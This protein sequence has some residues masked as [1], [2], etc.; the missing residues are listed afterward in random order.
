MSP[1]CSH[2]SSSIVA[3]VFVGSINETLAQLFSS[4]ALALTLVIHGEV[5]Q[6]TAAQLASGAGLVF[7]SV[8][9]GRHVDE[10]NFA[11][12]LGWTHRARGAGVIDNGS[13]AN[14]RRL[15]EAISAK[16]VNEREET[17]EFKI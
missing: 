13:R 2:P 16:R 9:H 8:A 3:A 6:P 15:R 17:D 14:C 1:V 5:D 12:G 7:R 10:L 11:G 4:H